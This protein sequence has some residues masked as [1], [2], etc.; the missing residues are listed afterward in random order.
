MIAM[1]SENDCNPSPK[2]FRW[3]GVTIAMIFQNHCNDFFKQTKSIGFLVE[4]SS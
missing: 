3:L 2:S 4:N 1:T